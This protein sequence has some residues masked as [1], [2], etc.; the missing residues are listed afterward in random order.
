[1]KIGDLLLYE[2]IARTQANPKAIGS[3]DDYRARGSTLV[4]EFLIRRRMHSVVQTRT[5]VT[6]S[7]A[8]AI[9]LRCR[10]GLPP[11]E[12]RAAGQ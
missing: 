2:T 12:Q 3:W 6:D 1:M 10:E 8:W 7:T 4:T 5:I 11:Q 9:G